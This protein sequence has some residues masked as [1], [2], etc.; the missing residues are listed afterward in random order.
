MGTRRIN[1]R[2]LRI[3]GIALICVGFAGFGASFPFIAGEPEGVSDSGNPGWFQVLGFLLIGAIVL[4]L[5]LIGWPT[6]HDIF[7]HR[8]QRRTD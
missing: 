2:S 1:R 5:I 6:A 4:G 8:R 3:L 7:S